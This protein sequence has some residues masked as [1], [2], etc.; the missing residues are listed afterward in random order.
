MNSGEIR[1]RFL[2]FMAE[3]GHAI[4]DSAS[5]V[6]SDEKG[7]TDST[8]F[9]TAGMQP[10]VPYLMGQDHPKG[11][12]LASSQK[13]VR[14]IDIDEVG[15]NTHATFF[16]MLGN[17][18]LG[19]YFKEEA[20]KL[21][22]QFLT[23][24]DKGLGLDP[25]KLYI[26]CFGGNED[27]PKDEE[28]AQIWQSLGI[29]K[30]RIYFLEDNWWSA[31]D[32][33]PCGSDSEMFYNV[34]NEGLGDLTHEEF[35][36]ADDEQKLVE[37]WNDVFMEF[38][39]KDG[40]VIGNLPNKNVDTGA[41]LERLTAVL[42]NRESIFDTDLFES[43]MNTTKEITS[44]IKNA[45]I[46]ADHIKASS[47]MIADGVLPSNTDRGYILRRI[48]RR[49]IFNTN[50]RNISPETVSNL[51]SSIVE[52]YGE[53]YPE[54]KN[55]S[56]QIISEI[57]KENE[58]FT[59]TISSAIKEFNK[60]EG[61]ISGKNAFKLFS[62][63]GLPIDL[64]KELANEQSKKVDI[65]SFEKE[66]KNH[67]EKSRSA[68]E[69][70]FKGGLA[71]DSPEEIKFHTATHLLHAGLREVL[72]EHVFQKGS[73]ITPDRLRFDFSHDEKMTDEQKEAVE[74]WVNEK[75]KQALPVIQKEMPFDEAKDLGAMGLFE[76][77]YGDKVSVYT[78][79]DENTEIC[80]IELCGGPHVENT[81]ELGKFKIKKEEASSR[82]VR[83]IK[84]IFE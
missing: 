30:G 44:D 43:L 32:N 35:L 6:T 11:K 51:V 8:L 26:T 83:R 63:H 7:V 73:N 25:D 27:A 53:H 40:K 72:G 33:G 76:D 66:F 69:G 77:K 4:L 50:D 5:L 52:I 34:T 70:K 68:A 80:S 59:K 64:V 82:G 19:D 65:K 14:T 36:K 20:I 24:K 3:N 12:R 57:N 48:L 84:A 16:E 42:Q 18:S 49:S 58:Q 2:D 47:F 55:N 62:T 21:S 17:W 67:Q 75:I 71:G 54:I 13:C 22:Y 45:R 78:I 46:V 37:I 61:N 15:D 74:N 28:S 60:I 1:K 9:N 56:E 10:L 81:E 23:D 39:K 38:E 41:G 29:P 79:G 31:G